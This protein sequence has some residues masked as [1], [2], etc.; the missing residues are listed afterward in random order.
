M[1]LVGIFF[2]FICIFFL[3]LDKLEGI[4]FRWKYAFVALI[5]FTLDATGIVISKQAFELSPELSSS[6]A[7]TY[8]ILVAVILL[9]AVNLSQGIPLSTKDLG[10]KTIGLLLISSLT[11]TFLA[12]LLWMQAIKNG[13]PTVIAALGSLTPVYSAIYDYSIRKIW[14]SRY[15]FIALLCMGI[16]AA[17]LIRQENL[18]T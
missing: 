4:D 11:G 17:I 8:R 3:S 10:R 12:L 2:I 7:N 1:I 15:F 9:A 18:P 13:D 14:P 16:G 5:G 6:T